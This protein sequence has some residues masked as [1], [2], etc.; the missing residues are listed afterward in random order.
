MKDTEL[1]GT[2]PKQGEFV[3]VEACCGSVSSLDQIK[4]LYTELARRP[5]K[6]FGWDK[7]S[8]NARRLGYEL[9]WLE[10]LPAA[11]W[12]SAAAV[13][14]P[15][16]LGPMHPGE[17]VIDVG[18]G[19]GADLCIA[20]LLVGNDG[21]VIGVDATPSMVE[22]ARENAKLAGLAN[23][24]V[25]EGNLARLPLPAACADVVIS[26]GAINLVS[27]KATAFNEIFRIL[28]RGGRLHFADMVRVQAR[29]DFCTNDSAESWANCVSGT[30]SAENILSTL[31]DAG[32][33]AV[34]LAG[35]T[36]YR[37]SESTRGALFRA[38]K[39]K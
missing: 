23:I 2:S 14:N 33:T 36:D 5:D 7:G 8:E 25:Y 19:A 9:A 12:E 27:D 32:F 39:P 34:E 10:R 1:T 20:S 30:L 11:V 35:H 18:C 28:R 24:E 6:S 31:Q 4:L 17:S 26:N 29:K 3:E 15:F 37:T 38:V 13:G 21:H 16:S 22:K